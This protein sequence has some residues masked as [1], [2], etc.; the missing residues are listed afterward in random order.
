MRSK[1]EW[2]RILTP[3]LIT[4]VLVIVSDIRANVIKVEVRMD[5]LEE[6]MVII[7]ERLTKVET[8]VDISNGKRAFKKDVS[9]VWEK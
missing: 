8:K 2:L 4:L 7:I 1:L 9:Q 6:K 3:I 5:R